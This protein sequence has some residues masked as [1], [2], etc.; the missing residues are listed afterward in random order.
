MSEN[1]NDDEIIDSS[2]DTEKKRNKSEKFC[3]LCRRP[4][5]K[6][7]PMIELPN[8]IHVCTDCM[9]KS[10]N[11]MNQQFNEGKFNYS[12][13]LNMPNVSMIDLGSFQNPVQ[14]PKKEKKKKKQEKP[15]L[16][17]KNIPAPHKIKETL[18]QYVIGQEKAK[19]VMSV[20]VYNHYKRV[21]TDT[22]DE[23]EIEKSNMLMIGPTGC[24]KT[25]LVKTLAKL[26]DVPLAIADATSLTEAGYIGDDIESVVSFSTGVSS[27][28]CSC[29]GSVSAVFSV[30]GSSG[31]NSSAGVSSG[32]LLP[33]SS[34]SEDTVSFSTFFAGSGVG[35]DVP[36]YGQKLTLISTSRSQDGQI[37]SPFR[38]AALSL[39]SLIFR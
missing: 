10:F 1:Y 5:S 36:Q 28:G 31:C 16:D 2:E 3:F 11:S 26:L 15:V 22:M 12:D 35:H 27:T 29:A 23:I 20:A 9:Q 7:G 34:S 37:F 19:K 17:L 14:Q 30:S 6:A 25:Y 33:S 24:G 4:E 38:F 39:Y 32:S 13:L 21:A 18:D 8:N